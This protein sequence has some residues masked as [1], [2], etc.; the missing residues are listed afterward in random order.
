MTAQEELEELIEYLE[1]DQLVAD[2][3]MPVP[4]AQLSRSAAIGLWALRVFAIVVS[5]M[6]IYTFI[7][8]L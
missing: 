2:R 7:A 4:R 3:S 1:R 5:A 6:V 8:Q